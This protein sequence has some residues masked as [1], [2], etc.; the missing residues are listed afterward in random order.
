MGKAG[1]V[2]RTADGRVIPKHGTKKSAS[3]PAQKNG[4]KKQRKHAARFHEW[5][6]GEGQ[7]KIG[8]TVISLLKGEENLDDWT[9]EELMKGARKGV[10]TP[11][12]IPLVVYQE[13]IKRI[14]AR[15]RHRFAAEVEFAVSV[16]TEMI[17]TW[18]EQ[19]DEFG[20]SDIPAAVCLKAI[21]MMYDR[22]LGKPDQTLNLNAGN[23][24]WKQLVASAIVGS[25][26]QL[27]EAEAKAIKAVENEMDIVEGEI[28]EED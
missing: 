8:R 19:M 9:D 20:E 4:K 26:D 14:E 28:V 16:H 1:P 6:N 15:V 3:Q 24:P 21:D 11:N 25:E 12:V 5:D 18:S 13:F 22:V 2:T 27:K 23:E 17:K 7:L 10:R